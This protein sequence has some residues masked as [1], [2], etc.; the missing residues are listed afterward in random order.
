M[1]TKTYDKKTAAF[2]GFL[3]QNIPADLSEEMMDGWMQNP[4]ALK[5]LLAGLIPVQN[6]PCFTTL[7]TRFAVDGPAGFVQVLRPERSWTY[8]E[9]VQSIL[10]TRST[11]LLW[12]SKQLIALDFTI[13]AAEVGELLLRAE[14]GDVRGLHTD[15]ITFSYF[16]QLGSTEAPVTIVRM[17]RRRGRW[18]SARHELN[19]AHRWVADSDRFLLPNAAVSAC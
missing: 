10:A 2:A 15:G 14:A 6:R 11:D 7:A 16:L 5:K 9:F 3:I 8:L 1:S 18:E 12:L 4:Q 17:R 19:F 13:T